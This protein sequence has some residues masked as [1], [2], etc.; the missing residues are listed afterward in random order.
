MARRIRTGLNTGADSRKA[1]TARSAKAV[2]TESSEGLCPSD[3]PTRSL[4]RTV[5]PVTHADGATVLGSF[6]CARSLRSL[7]VI[8][9]LPLGLPDTLSRSD[10]RASD[11]R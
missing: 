6:A 4:G 2:A 11:S 9:A 8:G 5:A 7:A 10:C 3:S 1:T